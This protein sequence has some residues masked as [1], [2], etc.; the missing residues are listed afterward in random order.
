LVP[1]N[2][3]RVTPPTQITHHNA[4]TASKIHKNVTNQI[5][6]PEI[7]IR[8]PTPMEGGAKKNTTPRQ[9]KGQDHER[10]KIT[11]VGQKNHEKNSTFDAVNASKS[12][13]Y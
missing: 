5:N 12:M 7:A 10:H 4:T 3:Q 6:M 2:S 13:Y 11:K 9:K 8:S 1:K